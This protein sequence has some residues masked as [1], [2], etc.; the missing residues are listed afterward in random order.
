M[1][2]TNASLVTIKSKA[3]ENPCTDKLIFYGIVELK[4]ETFLF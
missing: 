1:P 3:K 2:G 4:E